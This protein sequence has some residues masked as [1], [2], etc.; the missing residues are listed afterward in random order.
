MT[1]ATS[2]ITRIDFDADGPTSGPPPSN[3]SQ[4]DK[5]LMQGPKSLAVA[6]DGAI[7]EINKL[8]QDNTSKVLD[9]TSRTLSTAEETSEVYVFSA[10]GLGSN[11][12]TLLEHLF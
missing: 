6:R 9:I 5:L 3:R 7:G 11:V 8:H 12:R 1:S 10:Q 4:W 2:D